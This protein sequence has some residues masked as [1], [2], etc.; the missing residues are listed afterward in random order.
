[1]ISELE[2]RIH[3]LAIENHKAGLNCAESV[4]DALIRSG[5][6]HLPP[7]SVALCTGFGSGI[8]LTGHTCGALS[9]AI[10]ALGSKF[11]RPDPMATDEEVRKKELASKNYRVFNNMVH[12]FAERNGSALCREISSRCGAWKGPK[13]KELCNTITGDTAVMVL[14]Y[15]RMS[16]EEAFAL[17]YG[18][19]LGG[20]R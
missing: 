14:K 6:V 16:P 12:E 9:A 13:R 2:R 10:L 5:A 19:N 20:C 11:G 1:M 4:L 8:G 15:L 3:S 7:E 18:R 17:K